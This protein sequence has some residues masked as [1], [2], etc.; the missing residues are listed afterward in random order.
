LS[1]PPYVGMPGILSTPNANG[2]YVL[3]GHSSGCTALLLSLQVVILLI[4]SM[5]LTS[6]AVNA[7]GTNGDGGAMISRTGGT[8]ELKY[9]RDVDPALAPITKRAAHDKACRADGLAATLWWSKADKTESGWIELVSRSSDACSLQ[10]RP[11]MQ[12]RSGGGQIL[13]TDLASPR[14]ADEESLIVL[15]PDARALVR[16]T[17]GN[18]C[19]VGDLGAISV[20]LTLPYGGGELQIP[21][22]DGSGQ[23]LPGVPWCQDPGSHSIINVGPFERVR[24]QH[25]V[26]GMPG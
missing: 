24:I 8:P 10:G 2:G 22:R 6:C 15:E 7:P 3:I 26:N 13:P 1:L 12:L 4:L 20:V 11:R 21:R 5:F 25:F 19:Y 18:W 14:V 23:Q 9:T 17:W 16:F